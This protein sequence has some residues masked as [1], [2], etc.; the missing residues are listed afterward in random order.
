ME[1]SEAEW[2][3]AWRRREEAR[4]EPPND[5]ERKQVL[6]NIEALRVRLRLIEWELRDCPLDISNLWRRIARMQQ[7]L[8]SLQQDFAEVSW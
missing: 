2:N 7:R 6:E 8:H 4:G 3:E 1:Q 5:W